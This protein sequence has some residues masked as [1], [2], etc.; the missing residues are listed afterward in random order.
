M[1]LQWVTRTHESHR[2]REPIEMVVGS[3]S[4]L[5]SGRSRTTG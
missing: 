1:A 2:R 5:P 4:R 3:V